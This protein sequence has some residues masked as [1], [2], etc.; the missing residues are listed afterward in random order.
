MREWLSHVFAFYSLSLTFS[1]V[2]CIYFSSLL[3]RG[4]IDIIYKSYATFS[5]LFYRLS[6]ALWAIVRKYRRR[7]LLALHTVFSVP[8]PLNYTDHFKIVMGLC[9]NFRTLF[10]ISCCV[11]LFCIPYHAGAAAQYAFHFGH[12]SSKP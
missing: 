4:S 12:C 10:L 7:C 9:L 3:L 2:Y 1:S 6:S 8:P 5:V 11:L